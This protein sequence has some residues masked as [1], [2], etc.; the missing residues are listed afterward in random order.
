MKKQIKILTAALIFLMLNGVIIP[1][2]FADSP[3]PPP[4]HGETG[5]Q[6]PGG[7]APIGGGVFILALLGAGYGAAKIY[8]YKKKATE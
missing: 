4:S 3:P 8:N 6:V 2:A 7:G 1:T 5:N